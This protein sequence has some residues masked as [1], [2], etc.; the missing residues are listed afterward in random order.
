MTPPV[1]SRVPLSALPGFM[2]CGSIVIRTFFFVA[3]QGALP[4]Q[5]VL[6]PQHSDQIPADPK[7][8]Y[9]PGNPATFSLALRPLFCCSCARSAALH[10]VL[11]LLRAQALVR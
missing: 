10:A 5:T 4:I 11:R 7:S 6:Q 9:L 2:P 8:E 1:V 3:V